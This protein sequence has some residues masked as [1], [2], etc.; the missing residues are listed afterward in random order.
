[1]YSLLA[2]N[3]RKLLNDSLMT[4]GW[5]HQMQNKK[6]FINGVKPSLA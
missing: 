1:M 3:F 5:K 4:I 2:R 6:Q